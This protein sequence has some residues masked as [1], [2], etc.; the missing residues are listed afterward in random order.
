ME[1]DGGGAVL[2]VQVVAQAQGQADVSLGVEQRQNLALLFEIWA[3]G[4]SP[5]EAQT[6]VLSQTELA[7][8]VL[9]RILGQRLSRTGRQPIDIQHATVV[10]RL[11]KLFDVLASGRS[12]AHRL[13]D[14]DV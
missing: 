3:G 5:A 1:H 12:G 6:L 14:D 13:Q 4:V 8:S 9:M 7:P 2:G 11:L 10:T